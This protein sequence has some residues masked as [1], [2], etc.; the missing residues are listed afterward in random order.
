[1]ADLYATLR[2]LRIP[3]EHTGHAPRVVDLATRAD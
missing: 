2:A 1:M 3:N